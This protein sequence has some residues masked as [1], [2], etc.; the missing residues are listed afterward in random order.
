MAVGIEGRPAPQE[1]GRQEGAEAE[2]ERQQDFAGG[3]G[4][5]AEPSGRQRQEMVDGGADPEGESPS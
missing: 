4:R 2:P 5:F 1:P 3:E